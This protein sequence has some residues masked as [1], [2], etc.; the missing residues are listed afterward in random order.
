MDTEVRAH[1]DRKAVASL[2]LA[3]V[4]VLTTQFWLGATITAVASIALA[5]ASRRSVREDEHLRGTTLSLAGFLI[6]S[7]VLIFATVGPSLLSLFLYSL[8]PVPVG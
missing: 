7:G 4:A 5:L 2:A 8:A 1:I 3:I 6:A